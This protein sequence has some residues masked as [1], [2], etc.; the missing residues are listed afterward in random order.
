LA[1]NSRNNN[2]NNKQEQLYNNRSTIQHNKHTFNNKH[3]NTTGSKHRVCR[4]TG[5]NNRQQCR[6]KPRSH[7]S[8]RNNNRG[9]SQPQR[10]CGRHLRTLECSLN[11]NKGTCQPQRHSGHHRPTLEC[12][13]NQS[14]APVSST[15][16]KAASRGFPLATKRDGYEVPFQQHT[17]ILIR[18]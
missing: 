3:S 1:N 12:S 17:R 9:T 16:P 6:P 11:N 15:T 10:H 14:L 5:H 4:L 8:R 7:A 18:P 2:N 13:R